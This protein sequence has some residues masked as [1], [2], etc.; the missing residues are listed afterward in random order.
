MSPRSMGAMPRRWSRRGPRSPM[1]RGRASRPP[2]LRRRAIRGGRRWSSCPRRSAARGA[3]CTFMTCRCRSAAWRALPS[4]SR[5]W[6][7]R[8]PGSSARARRSARCST[9]C[10]PGSPSSR[11][12]AAW[13]FATSR[14]GECSRCATNGWP[15][16]RSSTACWNGCARRTGC[17]WCAI[18]P[19][20]RPSGATGSWR[21]TRRARR[22]GRCP[23]G[24]ISASSPSRCPKAGC[25]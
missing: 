10:P 25:W 13:C 8:A 15:T 1:C 7:R 5:S 11:P 6:N 3:C 21:P 2:A 23:V 12:T 19:A 24:R 14:S 17:R 20:G 9:D 4:M 22:I 16:G 18:S